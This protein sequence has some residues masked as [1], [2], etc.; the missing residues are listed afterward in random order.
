MAFSF[1]IMR[2]KFSA[3]MGKLSSRRSITVFTEL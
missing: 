2:K 1:S 3:K